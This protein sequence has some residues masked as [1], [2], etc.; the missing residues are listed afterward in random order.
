MQPSPCLPTPHPALGSRGGLAITSLTVPRRTH[1]LSR[2]STFGTPQNHPTYL[3]RRH[4]PPHMTPSPSPSLP[5]QLNNGHYTN[6][7]EFFRDI[8]LV[9]TNAMVFNM[10]NSLVFDMCARSICVHSMVG[11]TNV[12]SSV[13]TLLRAKRLHKEFENEKSRLLS[14]LLSR[15]H[16]VSHPYYCYTTTT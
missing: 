1:S 6:V 11:H 16:G 7:D 8:D 9:W 3:R 12:H 4:F 5:P 10:D 13:H 2:R 14:R 15:V